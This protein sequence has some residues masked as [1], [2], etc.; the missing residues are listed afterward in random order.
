M[1]GGGVNDGELQGGMEDEGVTRSWT[2]RYLALLAF[3]RAQ[4]DAAVAVAEGHRDVVLPLAPD[5]LHDSDL[6]AGVR[7]LKLLGAD[8]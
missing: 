3:V 7:L 6:E 4:R 5:D 8:E 1:E 2:E